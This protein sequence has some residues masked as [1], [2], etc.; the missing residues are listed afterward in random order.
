MKKVAITGA[1]GRVGSA[2]AKNIDKTKYELTLLDLPEHDVTDLEHLREVLKD[3][4][5]VVHCAWKELNFRE[6][7]FSSD[8]PLMTY[9]V[10]QAAL[11]LGVSRVV[12]A[13]SN[14]AN[15]HDN[16]NKQGKLTVDIPP[17]PDSPYGAAKVFMEALGKY[18]ASKGLGVVCVRIGNLNAED[19]PKP[20]SEE[21][22]Q[23]WLSYKDWTHLV[24]LALE[25]PQIPNNFVLLNGV[26]KNQLQIFDW[27]NPLGWEPQDSAK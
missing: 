27:S 4:Y 7:K 20:L 22:P 21:N 15:N 6:N 11:D 10:Y 16:R 19:E 8:D 23:R 5:A 26:S 1:K 25:A 9:N 2:L 3:H 14:H 18:Y 13:S 12:M 24:E 17:V